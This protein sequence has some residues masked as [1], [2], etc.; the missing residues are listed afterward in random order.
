MPRIPHPGNRRLAIDLTSFQCDCFAIVQEVPVRIFVVVPICAAL[1]TTACATIRPNQHEITF[2]SNPP[3]A[4]IS[5]GG[6]SWGVA[7]VVRVYA[8][9]Q[10]QQEGRSQPVTATWVSGASTTVTMRIQAGYH[11]DY[12]FQRPQAAGLDA[13]LRWAIHLQT[14]EAA[15]Q[16][17]LERAAYE[18]GRA[19]G[20]GSRSPSISCT[21]R[22][23]G[24][25]VFTDCD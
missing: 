12:T 1:M 25:S 14:R 10:G 15:A 5:S 3:G 19:I 20:G 13:D 18:A 2:R 24:R 9:A 21:S 16:A 7:P 17:E 8:L 22:A 6:Q 4:T 23:V 11:G